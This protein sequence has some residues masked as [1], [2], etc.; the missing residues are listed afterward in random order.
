MKPQTA[1]R[2]AAVVALTIVVVAIAALLAGG[3]SSYKVRAVFADV[4]AHV[5]GFRVRIDGAAVGKVSNLKLDKQDHVIATLELDKSASPIGPDARATVRAA[6]L[7]GEKY[8]DLQPGN[9]SNPVPSDSTIPLARTGLAVELD[10]VL[11]AI[12][13]PTQ[14]ALHTLVN[15]QGLAFA[16]RG[17]D[18]ANVL[19]TLPPSLDQTQQLLSQLAQN[20][21]TLGRLVSES[22]RV[23]A[24]V[25]AQKGSLERLVGSTSGT[26]GILAGRRAELGQTVAEAPAT[27]SSLRR[28]LAA[29]QSAAAPLGPAAQ[30]LANTAPQLTATLDQLP[31]FTAAAA[32]TLSIVRQ[33]S[34][35]LTTLGTRG[36]PVVKRLRPLTAQLATFSS[37]LQPVGTTLDK[38]I[39]DVLGL[40]EGWAR[41][42]QGRDTAGHVFRFGLTVSPATF[43]SLASLLTPARTASHRA[44]ARQVLSSVLSALQKPVVAPKTQPVSRPSRL[45]KSIAKTTTEATQTVTKLLE[46]LGAA[47]SPAS[48]PPPALKELI[49]YLLR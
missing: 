3:S 28:A 33:V 13:V 16:D 8:I 31:A 45:T 7:L 25:T 39:G 48:T 37:A 30:G 9:R 20:N 22:D 1:A 26:L 40:M 10:D 6:D 12:D 4:G 15:E 18:L 2:V 32:P 44:S 29:L 11:N 38:G 41:S 17:Q 21:G 24:A 34:P 5:K 46:Q 47:T 35:T 23:V 49:S 19:A 43:S 14:A 36:T 27:L 42:T